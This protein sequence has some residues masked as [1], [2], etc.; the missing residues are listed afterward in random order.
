[1]SRDRNFP[2]VIGFTGTRN[3]PSFEQRERLNYRLREVGMTEFHHGCCVGAD[4]YAHSVAV[5]YFAGSND[6]PIRLHPPV[7][8]KYMMPLPD[9]SDPL[10][11]WADP[12]PYL[13]RNAAIVEAT[14]Y[15]F[16]VPDSYED[17]PRSGTWWTIQQALWRG[18]PVEVI[19][20]NGTSAVLR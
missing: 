20:P 15:L 9:R 6:R 17:R 3:L 16:A 8:E 13:V 10:M 1:M 7:K 5:D 14:E 4:E 12:L 2:A 11:S 19:Y 18:R